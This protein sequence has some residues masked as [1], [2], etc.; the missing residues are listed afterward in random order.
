[1]IRWAS[2]GVAL[3]VGLSIARPAQSLQPSSSG[4]CAASGAELQV[5]RVGVDGNCFFRALAQGFAFNSGAQASPEAGCVQCC[6]RYNPNPASGATGQGLVGHARASTS[7]GMR[8]P[9]VEQRI[10]DRREEGVLAAEIRVRVV[11]ALQKRRDFLE[12]FMTM[13]WDTYCNNMSQSG[14]W[15]GAHR[16]APECAA[17]LPLTVTLPPPHG[18]GKHRWLRVWRAATHRTTVV[19]ARSTSVDTR[20]TRGRTQRCGCACRRARARGRACGAAGAR[21][22]LR[23]QGARV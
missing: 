18:A 14:T 15:G 17:V 20:R 2:S 21:A 9:L 16:S 7:L 23:A 1:M 12:P 8:A 13:P 3:A 11:K 22:R 10:L 4:R 6:A 19:A 5:V